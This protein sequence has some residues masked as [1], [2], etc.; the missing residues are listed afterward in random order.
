MI[1]Y[2]TKLLNEGLSYETLNSAQSALS[3]LCEVQDG[4]HVGSHPL[5][6]RYMSGVFNLR[7]TRPRYSETWDVSKVLCYLKMLPPVH[8]LTLKLLSYKLVTLIALTQASR[9][10]SI[11][12]LTLENI[13]KDETSFTVYYSGL[14]KQTRRGKRNPVLTLRKYTPDQRICVYSTLQEYISR[15]KSLRGDEK[16]L[17][18]SYIKPFKPVVTAT[19]SRW[20]RAVLTL[21]GIDVSKFKTHSTRCASTS[22]AKQSG[23][24][25][26][27]ILKVAGWGTDKTFAQFYEKPKEDV[28]A[29]E[30]AIL[31]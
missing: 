19:I 16:M 27:E 20:I 2:L 11:S 7:P 6:A 4:Y 13:Q 3:N 25:M 10:H 28:S 18:I 29:F 15:T 14:L 24:S 31:Q 12:L 26:T 21:S 1:E 8:K 5:V 17:L 22:K 23:V 9:S 30:E